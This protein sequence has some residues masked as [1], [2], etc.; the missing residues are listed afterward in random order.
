[1]EYFFSKFVLCTYWTNMYIQVI[2]ECKI[3][4]VELMAS[5]FL[6]EKI[7]KKCANFVKKIIYCLRDH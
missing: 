4:F 2:I 7:T 5:I 6:K 3:K 1:M